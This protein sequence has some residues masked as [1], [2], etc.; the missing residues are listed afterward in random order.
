VK[1]HP[2]PRPL[3][4]QLPELKQYTYVKFKDQILVINPMT[5]KIV[6]LFSQS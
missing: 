3:I 1:A 5:Q 6:D 2:L 4:D